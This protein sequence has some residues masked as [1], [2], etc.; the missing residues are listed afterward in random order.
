MSSNRHLPVHD[1]RHLLPLELDGVSPVLLGQSYFVLLDGLV[2]FVQHTEEVPLESVQAGV[3]RGA[4][5]LAVQTAG[6]SGTAGRLLVES[7]G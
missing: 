4:G 3:G 6:H 1:E 5:V 2:H 7:E